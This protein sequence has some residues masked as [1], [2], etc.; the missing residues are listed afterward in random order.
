MK[1]VQK[2]RHERI[3]AGHQATIIE[4]AFRGE[5]DRQVEL[6]VTRLTNAYRQGQEDRFF[7]GI[8]AE[9]TALKTL[10]TN[11]ET[12]QTRGEVAFEQEIQDGEKTSSSQY[13]S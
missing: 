10:L 8:A 12:T 5:I 1:N 11:L 9:I 4:A 2:L 7:F 3:E 6:L 13:P